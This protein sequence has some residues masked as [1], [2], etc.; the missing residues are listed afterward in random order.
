MTASIVRCLLAAA[1]IA[2]AAPA[3]ADPLAPLP[4]A[5]AQAAPTSP[6]VF[7]TMAVGAGVTFYDARFRRVSS[8]D[9]D[10]PLLVELA[11]SLKGLTPEQQLARVKA[12]VG[13]RVQWA[14][15]LTTM[16]VADLW[17]NAGETL[18]R[19]RGDSE[20]I[21]IVEMQALKLAGWNAQDLYLSIG[22]QKPV[23]RHIVLLA[24]APSGFYV[25][26]YMANGVLTP[27]QHGRF[28]PVITVGS[29]KSWIHGRRVAGSASRASAR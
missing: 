17:G 21:A 23:G 22:R 25:L 8:A 6:D 27:Q 9:R 7:G 14:D 11:T 5:T 16:R 4:A 19:G 1:S 20:D 26:D 15:D 13:R 29:G 18:E 12:E 10:H 28:T 2:A 24:R 3:A